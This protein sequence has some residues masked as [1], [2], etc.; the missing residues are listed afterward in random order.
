MA[1]A[2]LVGSFHPHGPP[3]SP[4]HGSGAVAPG[5][6][7][8]GPSKAQFQPRGSVG[9]EEEATRV[10]LSVFLLLLGGLGTD[11]LGFSPGLWGGELRASWPEF[12]SSLDSESPAKRLLSLQPRLSSSPGDAGHLRGPS[13]TAGSGAEMG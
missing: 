7:S 4:T 12:L 1:P 13:V 6:S 5:H 9:P 10:H 8:P 11:R 3:S 2:D